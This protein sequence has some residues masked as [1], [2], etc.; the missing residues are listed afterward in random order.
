[1]LAGC[2]RVPRAEHAAA[3]IA[4]N[5]LLRRVLVQ[6]DLLF[7]QRA[8]LLQSQHP[9]INLPSHFY[10]RS[11]R[12]ALC[13]ALAHCAALAQQV[14]AVEVVFALRS[15]ARNALARLV[16]R[17]L[18]RVALALKRLAQRLHELP[19][20]LLAKHTHKLFL[21]FLFTGPFECLFPSLLVRAALQVAQPALD[22][23]VVL[24]A[25]VQPHG[26]LRVVEAQ[27]ATLLA[28][29]FPLLEAASHL[30]HRFGD[31]LRKRFCQRLRFRLLQHEVGLSV[32][33]AERVNKLHA[34]IPV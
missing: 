14:L 23:H 28:V 19:A 7:A 9:K 24:L 15:R 8:L 22:A 32:R 26:L 34:H 6:V 2:L 21:C 4:Q 11:A 5:L 31:V 3:P 33:A 17:L 20:R 27:K 12:L 29:V 10:R 1:M 30:L 16:G 18:R 13:H 25:S